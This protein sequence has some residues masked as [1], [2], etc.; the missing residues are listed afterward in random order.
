MGEVW[1]GP[2]SVQN[3]WS[4]LTLVEDVDNPTEVPGWL[5]PCGYIGG[6]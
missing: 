2:V 5:R 4:G 3:I 1:L 6:R